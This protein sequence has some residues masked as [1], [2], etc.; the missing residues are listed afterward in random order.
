M[1]DAAAYAGAVRRPRAITTIGA[2]AWVAGERAAVIL[3]GLAVAL[4]PVAV[5]TGP[6]NVAPIDLFIVIATAACLMWGAAAGVS[7]RFPYALPLAIFMAG[8]AIGALAGPVPG[9]GVVAIVQDVVLIVWCWVVVNLSRSPRN[10][11]A[12]ASTWVYTSIV[13]AIMPIV[14]VIIGSAALTGQTE[15]QGSRVQIT[16]ADPSYA[17]NYF[18]ISIMLIWATGRPR[19]QGL[20]LVAYALLVVA[21]VLTGSNSGMLSLL[22]GTAVAGVLG[23]YRRFGAMSAVA[24]LVLLVLSA[25]LASLSINLTK[26]QESAQ[27]SR[28]AFIRDGIGRGTSVSQRGM[29]LH[30]S[31]RLLRDGGPLGEGPVSTKVRLARAQAPF[32]KEAHDDYLA[33]LLERGVIGF[34]GLVA[35]VYGVLYRSFAFSRSP[36]TGG[37]GA[38]VARPHALAGAVAGTLVAGAVY[39]LL[40]VRHVW[41]LFGLVAALYIWARE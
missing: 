16:L 4:L 34:L 31:I 21:I 41:A 6:A 12:L 30:E 38:V 28:Y 40:H 26:I 19:H 39:E 9:N 18:F 37:F 3:T 20:R 8:G 35:L 11:S 10:F 17:A 14:G 2:P 15:N 25:G 23:I 13:W 36:L 5:P 32:E 24:A 1:T 22:V 33:A 27:S 7:W 29:L